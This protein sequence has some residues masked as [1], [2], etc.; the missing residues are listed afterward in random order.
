MTSIAV[1]PSMDR[2]DGE[3]Q[4]R[5]GLYEEQKRASGARGLTGVPCP[6]TGRRGYSHLSAARRCGR[7]MVNSLEVGQL[8]GAAKALAS[9]PRLGFAPLPAA[10]AVLLLLAAASGWTLLG[11]RGVKPTDAKILGLGQFDAA[12]EEFH[13]QAAS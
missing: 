9:K 10:I 5:I 12:I 11:W 8:A 3:R 1:S 6:N 7:R 13:E 4:R 2:G